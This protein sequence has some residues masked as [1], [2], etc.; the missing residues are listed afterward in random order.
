MEFL[1]GVAIVIGFSMVVF[2]ALLAY[3]CCAVA[4]RADEDMERWDSEDSSQ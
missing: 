4:K 3:A 1:I 2:F